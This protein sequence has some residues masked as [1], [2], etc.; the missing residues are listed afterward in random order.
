MQCR[1]GNIE[2]RGSWPPVPYIDTC[3]PTTAHAGCWH[4]VWPLDRTHSDAFTGD[5]RAA[6]AEP[7]PGGTGAVTA[8][9]CSSMNPKPH[10]IP[11]A[12]Q[13]NGGHA[14]T[15]SLISAQINPCPP[16]TAET[17]R[18]N[19]QP[20]RPPHTPRHR[21]ATCPRAHTGVGVATVA[22][23]TPPPARRA[24]RWRTSKH[25]AQVPVL[26][27]GQMLHQAEEV[28][29]SRSHGSPQ[30]VLRQPVN[31]GEQ[32]HPSTMQP[33]PQVIPDC[34]CAGHVQN[35]S[36]GQTDRWVSGRDPRPGRGALSVSN[37][38]LPSSR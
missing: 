1:Q 3:P 11:K 17:S 32:A 27:A 13:P 12:G 24:N 8:T 21:P 35:R 2:G 36:R 31:L 5:T 26:L 22:A 16:V 7:D 29:S 14:A 15:P 34:H 33:G 9:R 38:V 37:W 4:P 10:R 25:L 20:H 18:P 19:H 6:A 23:P 30:V 28:R